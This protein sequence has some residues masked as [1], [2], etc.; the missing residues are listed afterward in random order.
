MLHMNHQDFVASLD[1]DSRARLV[2]RRDGPAALRLGLQLLL[3]IA[4]GGFLV[5]LST[6]VG[7][8]VVAVVAYGLLAVLQGFWLVFMFTA[9]HELI[10]GTAFRRTSLNRAGAFV[11]GLLVFVAPTWFRYFHYEHHRHT[12]DPERD[13]ELLT[14]KPKSLPAHLVYL[15]GVPEWFSRVATILSHAVGRDPGAFVPRNAAPTV[16]REARIFVGCYA[17]IAAASVWW[18]SAVVLYVWLIPYVLGGPFL[19]AYLLAEHTGCAYSTDML[20]NTR[21][22]YTNAWMRWFT[23]NMP[24]HAEHHTLPSVPFHQ[25]PQLHALM[26]GFLRETASGYVRFNARFAGTRARCE[27]INLDEHLREGASLTRARTNK[28]TTTR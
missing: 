2:E 8:S 25:L 3:L 15:T 6:Q 17:A 1:A 10:H 14:A 22:T 23:W 7:G 21:T 12:Q 13:P 16:R 20:E 5:H 19:R 24:Y 11:A 27:P 18:D 4:N 9:L 28:E 26:R